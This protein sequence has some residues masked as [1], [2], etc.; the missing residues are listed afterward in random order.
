MYTRYDIHE[1]GNHVA[2]SV[3]DWAGEEKSSW[4]STLQLLSK[5]RCLVFFV[6]LQIPCQNVPD[7]I[8]SLVK[9]LP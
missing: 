7:D 1:L 6:G 4:R 9:W 8:R 3:V 2:D 5:M